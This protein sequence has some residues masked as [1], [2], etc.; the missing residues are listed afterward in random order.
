VCTL[1]LLHVHA[2]ACCCVCAGVSR[3]CCSWLHLLLSLQ[4]TIKN[5]CVCGWLSCLQSPLPPATCCATPLLSRGPTDGVISLSVTTARGHCVLTACFASHSA[6]RTAVLLSTNTQ[7]VASLA[8]QSRHTFVSAACFVAEITVP[9]T[10][11]LLFLLTT[12]NNWLV[13]A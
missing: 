9:L 13:A 3:L 12:G 6:L 7:L 5:I 4:P 2:A 8:A 1:L 11:L 10:L